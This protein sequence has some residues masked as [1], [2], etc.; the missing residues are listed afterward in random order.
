M[1]R[2]HQSCLKRFIQW[3]FRHFQRLA[4]KPG[5]IFQGVLGNRNQ[6]IGSMSGNATAIAN[7]KKL[8][9]HFHLSPQEILPLQSFWEN[10]SQETNPPFSLS[11]V[12]GGRN[13]AR[14]S[15]L[16]WLR[17][18]PG[19]LTLQG[20]SPEEA[21]AFLAA[22]VQS[23]EED[24][25]TKA[26]LRAVVVDGATAWQ[27]L[28]T[29]SEP[30][31][32]IARLNQPEGVGQAVQ[33]GHHV[34]IPA[35]RIG[36]GDVVLPRI[37]RDA[38]EKALEEMGLNREQARDL[39]TLARRSLPALRRKRAIAQGIRH[40]AWARPTEARQLLAPLLA[41]AWNNSCEGDRDALAQ[42]S[43]MPYEQLEPILV[44][45]AHEPDPP[46]RRVGDTWMITVQEDAW[47][48]IAQYLTDDDLQRFEKVALDILSE[49]DPAFELPP[50][51]R[52]LANI[53]GKVL[54]RSGRLRESVAETLALTATLSSEILFMANRTGGDVVHSIVWRLLEKAKDNAALW[55]SLA[56]QLPLLAEAAPGIFLK[57]VEVGLAGESPILVSLFQDQTSNAAL[58]GFSP[59]TGLLWALE[60]L[61]WSPDYLSSAALN[62]AR[63]ARL[64]PGGT[65]ANRPMHSLRDI[66]ICWHP[67][68]TAPLN[69]R[70]RVLDTIRRQEP[71]IAWNLLMQL[72]P[73]YHSTVSPTHGTKW[74]NWV[75]DS[76]L[77]PTVQEYIDATNAILERLLPDA[78]INPARWCN[79]IKSADGMPPEQREVL[80]QHLEALDPALFPAN[81]RAQIWHCLRKETIRHRDFADSDWAMPAESVQRMEGIYTR[82][83]PAEP[84][85]RYGWLF[86][87]NVE[88]AGMLAVPWSEREEVVESLRTEALQCI[89]KSQ[90]WQGVL[91]LVE[92][93][94]EPALVGIT[95]GRSNLLPIDVGTFLQDNLG[96]P[97]SWRNQMARSF[98]SVCATKHGEP[99]IEACLLT[100]AGAW[101][102]EQY[103][104]FLLCLPFSLPLLDRLD[105]LSEE[106]QR[107]FWSHVKHIGFL[108]AIY[109]DRLLTRLIEF[110]RP[111]LAVINV[112]PWA[113]EHAPETV[114]SVGIAEILEVSVQTPL[115]PDFD[116]QSFAY[117][118]AELFNYLEKTD[119]FRDRL[120]RLEW[121]YLRIHDDYRYPRILQEEL[122]QNPEFFVEVLQYTYRTKNE[123]QMEPTEE[124]SAGT[125][126]A[127]ELLDSW[128]KMPGV[129]ADDSV[130]AEA[131]HRWVM[132]VRE[133]AAACD[134]SEIADIHIGH[135]FAFSPVGSD[136]VWPHQSVRDLIEELE[137]SEIETGWRTQTFNNRGATVRGLTDGGKQELVLVE[138]YEKYANQ[139]GDQWQRTAI[140]LREMADRYRRQAAQEDQRAELTQDFWR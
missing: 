70:L 48:L 28:I 138:E 113:I 40:P 85:T 58:M 130:D 10:W 132:R 23:L 2:S 17:G 63:L 50:E 60:T 140:I 18:I 122:A 16:S 45:W 31:I 136:R 39:A 57:A 112:I 98:V 101:N 24:E 68:T 75:P 123:P 71:N 32:L 97:E 52:Y 1:R 137:S 91:G 116:A 74:R 118:S 33:H 110:A 94:K 105:A 56:Y 51:Q 9:Q 5:R 114:S 12:I 69:R 92:Q 15:V 20:E 64:D 131:L 139:I 53:Y 29:S 121:M 124:A 21:I 81:E 4:N 100:N 127:R 13:Q 72:L 42:L 103:G 55:A 61:A 107:Y 88:L 7:V 108:N 102:P 82:F 22:V 84:I 37:V 46:L 106:I 89:L 96:A 11:L 66:F 43:G 26:L 47:R 54:T 59:H 19:P 135:I 6:V 117:Y 44:R 95:L 3:L 104:T 67:N 35:G 65:L 27:R 79:L 119:L 126:L 30:L 129:Q 77:T 34:F 111:H 76:R 49:L 134:R 8:I 125:L 128:H 83:E 86:S 90:G 93:V 25:R 109:I 87:Y 120:A 78:Q 99:G 14:D 115:G 38:A 73:Q 133:L 80:L 62:L 41:G 36:A